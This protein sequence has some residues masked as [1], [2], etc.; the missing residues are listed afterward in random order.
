MKSVRLYL[1]GG[2]GQKL[3]VVVLVLFCFFSGKIAY[4]HGWV[5]LGGRLLPEWAMLVPDLHYAVRCFH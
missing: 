5:W 3:A 2:K 1:N 4:R